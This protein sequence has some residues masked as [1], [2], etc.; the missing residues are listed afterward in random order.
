MTSVQ[1]GF[2]RFTLAPELICIRK[3]STDEAVGK[4][5]F[6]QP[7]ALPRPLAAERSTWTHRQPDD[8]DNPAARP[9]AGFVT[10]GAETPFCPY[11][12]PTRRP[13]KENGLEAFAANP[14]ICMVA[15]GGIEPPTRGFSIPEQKCLPA[16]IASGTFYVNQH[17]SFY[18]LDAKT[19]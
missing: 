3:R 1:I 15:W 8:V 18:V 5:G 2:A 10:S 16:L 9:R 17:F 13:G 6:T 7:T 14:L 19:D 4:P 11:T 12:A